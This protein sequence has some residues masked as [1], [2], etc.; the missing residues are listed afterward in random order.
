MPA[1]FSV[2]APSEIVHRS[3]IRGL[4]SRQPSVVEC[5][6]WSP[7]AYAFSGLSRTAGARDIDSTPPTSTHA[8]SP[9]STIRLACMAA[10]SDEPQRRLTVVA[11]TLVGRPASSTAMRPTLR[12]SSPAWLA[13]PK[14][15][16]SIRAGSRLGSRA[17]SSR[18][19][20]AAR[21]SGRTPARPPP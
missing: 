7:I 12:L 9:L 8:A 19:T 1:S 3:G 4:T 18:T 14:I 17:S 21:S 10:S 5:S 11:G 2:L 16:S 15:T 6:V 20:W 13:S